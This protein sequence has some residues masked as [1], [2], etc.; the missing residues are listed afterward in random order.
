MEGTGGGGEERAVEAWRAGRRTACRIEA[1]AEALTLLRGEATLVK[2]TGSVSSLRPRWEAKMREAHAQR[3]AVVRSSRLLCTL[4]CLLTPLLLL[5]R[6]KNAL[7]SP[8]PP[9][10]PPVEPSSRASSHES[11]EGRDP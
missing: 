6:H 7:P 1:I 8:P 11:A 9:L 10:A 3:W 5:V 2:K 4:F